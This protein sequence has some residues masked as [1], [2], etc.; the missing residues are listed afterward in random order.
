MESSSS[1]SQTMQCK[2]VGGQETPGALYTKAN[3]ARNMVMCSVRR[4]QAKLNTQQRHGENSTAKAAESG[5]RVSCSIP[6]RKSSRKRAGLQLTD[7]NQRLWCP[8][9][10]GEEPH[11]GPRECI[12]LMKSCHFTSKGQKWP[13]RFCGNSLLSCSLVFLMIELHFRPS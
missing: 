8:R 12:F 11:S 13:R 7:P 4:F 6:Y 3:P 10:Q 2:C 1:L 5:C 9:P